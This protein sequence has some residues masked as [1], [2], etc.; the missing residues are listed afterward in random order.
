LLA[1]T[2]LTFGINNLFNAAP[3]LSAD[4][5]QGFDTENTNA[6]GRFYYMSFEK[7]F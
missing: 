7:K 4:W 6:L 1:N 5:F 2:T 3:P